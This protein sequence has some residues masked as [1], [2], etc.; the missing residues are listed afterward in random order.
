MK[1]TSINLLYTKRGLLP[2]D[3]TKAAH[4]FPGACLAGTMHNLMILDAKGE[5]CLAGPFNVIG[6]QVPM[7]GLKLQCLEN[8]MERGQKGWRY[9]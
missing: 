9:Q 2:K 5:N 6:F 4:V 3:R 8:F 7:N 1:F